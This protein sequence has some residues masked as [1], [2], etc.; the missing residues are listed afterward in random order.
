MRWVR[1]LGFLAVPANLALLAD[2]VWHAEPV[3]RTAVMSGA[4]KCMLAALSLSTR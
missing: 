4:A 2:M 3:W 1:L